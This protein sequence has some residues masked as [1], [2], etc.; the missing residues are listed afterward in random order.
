MDG[1]NGHI[2]VPP[3]A[4]LDRRP[5]AMFDLSGRIALVTGGRRGIGRAIALTL[6]GHGAAVAVHHCGGLEEE[7]DAAGVVQAVRTQ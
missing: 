4:D 6:A 3:G 7:A 2:V 5:P 1:M